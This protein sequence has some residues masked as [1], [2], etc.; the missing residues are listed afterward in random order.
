MKKKLS[1]II[2]AMLLAAAYMP[3]AASAIDTMTDAP[4]GTMVIIGV[5]TK[6]DLFVLADGNGTYY[7]SSSVLKSFVSE[8]QQ[9][10]DWFHI[11]QF[12]EGVTLYTNEQD[13]TDQL[14]ISADAVKPGLIETIGYA[15]DWDNRQILTVQSVDP[16]KSAV[17]TDGEKTYTY[18][19]DWM[20][21]DMKAIDD[22]DWNTIEPG[23]TVKCQM[24]YDVPVIASKMQQATPSIFVIT[25]MEENFAVMMEVD[26]KQNGHY[27]LFDVSDWS[28]GNQFFSDTLAGYHKGD[29]IEFTGTFSYTDDEEIC[30]FIKPEGTVKK[31]GSVTD[32][33]QLASFTETYA[34]GNWQLVSGDGTSTPVHMKEEAGYN[35][36]IGNYYTYCGI[37]IILDSYTSY[38]PGDLNNDG[39]SNAS[40]AAMTLIDAA[41]TGAGKDSTLTEA[42]RSA[43]DCNK[44]GCVNASDAADI[45]IYAA[46][47]GTGTFSGTFKEYVNS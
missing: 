8:D 33:P 14:T 38:A 17:L 6:N 22:V 42:Q 15:T 19:L 39:S 44:D 37:P 34:D 11:L 27:M 46:E 9:V 10:P 23:M 26:K 32:N 29:V 25:Q 2:A 31:T 5:D 43:A 40:D 1:V 12:H 47:Y 21:G 24:L 16:G 4:D 36:R 7:T 3:I 41:A 45:L 30:L 18:A 13:G 35:G 20:G 28:T